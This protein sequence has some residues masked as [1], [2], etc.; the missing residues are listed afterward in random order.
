MW[1]L[2]RPGKQKWELFSTGEV[3]G[4]NRIVF[5][6]TTTPPEHN[7]ICSISMDRQVIDV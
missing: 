6:I 3:K 4:H 5:N 7:K 2:N 1:D